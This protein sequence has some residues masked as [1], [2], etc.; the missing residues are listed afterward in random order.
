M[1]HKNWVVLAAGLIL[2]GSILI[3]G[4]EK[5]PHVKIRGIYGGVPAQKLGK[6]G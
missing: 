2:V 5:G 4:E 6:G 1:I 3:A